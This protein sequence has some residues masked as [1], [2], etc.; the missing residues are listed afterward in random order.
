MIDRVS[1]KFLHRNFK[2]LIDYLHPNDCLVLNDTRVFPARLLGKKDK[3]CAQVE[4]F[5]LRKLEEN[6]WEVLVKPAR[7]VRIGNKILF[8]ETLFCDVIDNTLSGGRIVEFSYNG[9]FYR[10]YTY[11]S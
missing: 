2:D 7:K 9:N 1:G 11:A 4:V 6:L 10:F 3:T 8:G 5:L